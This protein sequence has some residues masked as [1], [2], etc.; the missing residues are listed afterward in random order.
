MSGLA[1]NVFAHRERLLHALRTGEELPDLSRRMATGSLLWALLY[2]LVLGAQVG[3]W[4]VA[5]SPIKLPL[6]LMGTGV[7]CGAAL[8]V[9]LS[10]AGAGLQWRQVLG[11]VLCYVAAS[12]VTM[13][14]VLPITAFWTLVFH[15]Q[16]DP[17]TL[18]HTGAFS[19]CG[20]VGARFGLEMATGLFREQRLVRLTLGWMAVYG[21]VAQQMAYLF[22]PHFNPTNVFMRPLSSGGS[23]LQAIWDTLNQFLR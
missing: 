7:I 23:S 1:I 22:R 18:V 8:Y 2:G 21:L 6:I 15:G 9:M 17:I 5:S 14:C 3:G 4:Q 11:L 16:R 12:G 19:V 13:G 20:V 10:L